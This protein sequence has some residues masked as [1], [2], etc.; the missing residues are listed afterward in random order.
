MML[1]QSAGLLMYRKPDAGPGSLPGSPGIFREVIRGLHVKQFVN[2]K[3]C[4]ETQ[5][6][7]LW[8]NRFKT[9]TDP[10]PLTNSLEALAHAANLDPRVETAVY[11]KQFIHCI[12]ELKFVAVKPYFTCGQ[13]QT[14]SIPS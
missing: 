1:K 11:E 10:A 8:A 4:P 2:P 3:P 5:T 6:T 12:E 7:R 14:Y 13:L 9:E